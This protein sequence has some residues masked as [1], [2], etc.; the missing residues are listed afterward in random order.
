M[1]F[2]ALVLAGVLVFTAPSV[3]DEPKGLKVDLSAV[4][5][6]GDREVLQSLIAQGDDLSQPR[7][8]VLYFYRLTNSARVAPPIFD[9]IVKEAAKLGLSVA[10]RDGEELVLEGVLR[11]DPAN[12]EKLVDWAESAAKRHAADF[13]GWECAVIKARK[14]S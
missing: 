4:S 10:R 3:G 7:H 5:R 12:I 1:R 6:A 8:T 2:G 11:V 14:S 9:A 13:D